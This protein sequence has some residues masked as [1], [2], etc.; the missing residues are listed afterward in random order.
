MEHENEQSLNLI[1]IDSA[2]QHAR[3]EI[4]KLKTELAMVMHEHDHLLYVE[5]ENIMAQYQIA[6]GALEYTVFELECETR[7]L[8]RKA[9]LIRAKLNRQER[10]VIAEIEEKL[11]Q[12]FVAYQERLSKKMC[13]MNEA[14]ERSQSGK[15]LTAEE[16]DQL[17]KLYRK[18]IKEL[19]P[20]INP[21]CT[22]QQ[23][24]LFH[25][26]VEAYK[27]GDL[28]R[29]SMISVLVDDPLQPQGD[30]DLV[31]HFESEK[32]RLH[33]MLER[34][35]ENIAEIKSRFPYN[36]KPLLFSPEKTVAYKDDLNKK[37]DELKK[38][39]EAW[40]D[41]IEKLIGATP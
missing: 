41:E 14:L 26:A 15:L 12:E 32:K 4:D 35:E 39:L 9:Q 21:N 33:R 20:D 1:S 11:D 3:E 30:I 7:R 18:I 19:H 22:Q 31:F 25:N 36:K 5:C 34:V 29:M 24:T 16:E 23:V 27:Y 10:V 40:R 6:F 38:V 2:T 13:E 28:E 8:E 37:I 17:K